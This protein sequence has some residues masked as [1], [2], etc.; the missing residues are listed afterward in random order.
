MQ[1]VARELFEN[2]YWM[3]VEERAFYSDEWLK[4]VGLMGV[5]DMEE[6]EVLLK[7]MRQVRITIPMLCE[8]YHKGYKLGF[9]DQSD[10]PEMYDL[11]NKHLNNW[12]EITSKLGYVN[13]IPPI[14]DFE[15]LDDIAEVLFSYRLPDKNINALF[16]LIA[17]PFRQPLGVSLGNGTYKRYSPQLYQYCKMVWG[18]EHASA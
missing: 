13:P 4:E 18:D 14:E 15:Q 2:R 8:Y 3:L 11:V 16:S 9:V 17:N 5:N 1:S 12:L 7:R 10:A 6:A